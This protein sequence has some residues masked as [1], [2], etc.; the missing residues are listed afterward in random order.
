MKSWNCIENCGACCKFNLDERSDLEDKLNSQDIDLI[1]KMT[2]Q[3][4][5]ANFYE[6]NKQ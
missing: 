3:D 6:S 1:V 2:S 5:L 4:V